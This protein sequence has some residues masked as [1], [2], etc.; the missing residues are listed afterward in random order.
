M[1]QRQNKPKKILT[2]KVQ[3]EFF[4]LSRAEV[5]RDFSVKIGQKMGTM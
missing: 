5:F 4:T 3:K 2:Y 1:K